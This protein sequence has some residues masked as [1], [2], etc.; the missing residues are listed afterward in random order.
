MSAQTAD[1]LAGLSTDELKALRLGAMA[2]SDLLTFMAYTWDQPSPFLAGRH[3]V[4][5]CDRLTRAVEDWRH[6]I[7]TYLLIAVP[8]R[9]GKSET[10]S[11]A[12][13]AWFLGRCADREP[14][15]IMCGYGAQLVAGFSRRA[16][17]LIRAARY[18]TIF[19][20]LWTEGTNANWN[21]A[22]SHG[23]VTAVGLG[24]SITGKGGH[25]IVLDDYCKSRAEAVSRTFRDKTW[26]SFRNDLMTRMNAPAHIVVVTATPWHVDDIRG[27]ILEHMGKDPHFPQFEE[28][29]FPARK[30]G[31]DGWDYLFPELHGAEWYDAQRA[32]LQKQAAALLDCAPVV[33]GG[34]RFDP[35]KVVI[36]DTLEGWPVG[37][38]A[39]GWDLASSAKDRDKDDPDW[40]WGVRGLS[41]EISVGAGVRKRD[42]WIRSMVA[43]RA[44]APARDALIRATAQADGPGVA[45]HVEAFAAYKDAYTQLRA[46]LRGY[47]VRPS[48]LPGDKSAKLAALEPVFEAGDVHVYA[49]GCAPW[50]DKWSAEFAAFPDGQHDDGCDATGVL[51]HAFDRAGSGVVV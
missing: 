11:I 2:R 12:L 20:G 23:Q 35:G 30:P 43:V 47:V 10:C 34:N 51:F 37:R 24:G 28:M 33:E 15:V 42:L 6:G 49:P 1:F 21:V 50:L 18:Q 25:L 39:R 44:E 32:T 7:S 40:T 14:S 38:E 22:G 45:Q 9:H 48:R 29:T 8:F 16:Q 13:P 19:P 31:P 17:R 36:H 3:T 41:R 26:D 27:R 46:A 4:A 5:I